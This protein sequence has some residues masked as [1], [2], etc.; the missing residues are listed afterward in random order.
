M[1][2]ETPTQSPVADNT[3]TTPEAGTDIILDLGDVTDANAPVLT[4]PV[5]DEGLSALPPSVHR[6]LLNIAQMFVEL[7]PETHAYRLVEDKVAAFVELAETDKGMQTRIRANLDQA[8]VD[9]NAQF[10]SADAIGHPL[11]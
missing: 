10:V 5:V 9:W 2:R 11:P 6:V 3:P 7:D 8:L 1:T 4:T